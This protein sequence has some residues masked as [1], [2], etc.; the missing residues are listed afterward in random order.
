M[1]TTTARQLVDRLFRSLPLLLVFLLMS[2]STARADTGDQLRLVELFTS[3]GCSSCPAADRLLGELLQQDD[4]LLGLEFHVDYW[5]TL[6]HGNAGSWVDPFSQRQF[7]DRQR[8]YEVS[9][10]A[11]RPGVYTPQAVVNGQVALVGSDRRSIQRA[12]Q[13]GQ[14]QQLHIGFAISS[15]VSAKP[16][17]RITL[18]AE[19]AQLAALAGTAISLL[20]YRDTA[21]TRITAG[22]NKDLVHV[23][24]HIVY[25]VA[26]LGQIEPERGLSFTVAP[27]AEDEG[28]VVL[29][30]NG[31]L[32]PV[33]AAA[34]CP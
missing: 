17:M 4:Q 30:Q 11:G 21:S 33:F 27:P 3:H 19:P 29:V 32:T 23:N 22:E 20:R 24:H 1:N 6:V 25:A 9:G 5:N 26:E 7:T 14:T 2:M 34:E 31:A 16:E 8:A 13:Q 15:P 28:C 12:L 18:S 10:L